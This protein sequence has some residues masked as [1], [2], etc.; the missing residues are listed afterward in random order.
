[1][2]RL[3]QPWRAALAAFL[4]LSGPVAA[5]DK[6]KADLERGEWYTTVNGRK[7]Y[8]D[9]IGKSVLKSMR[10]AAVK[11]GEGRIDPDGTYHDDIPF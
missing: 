4:L 6:P 1:M 11:R 8:G 5:D 3:P 10:D 9:K 2:T 7:V